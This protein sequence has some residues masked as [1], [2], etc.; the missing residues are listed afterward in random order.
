MTT[1]KP[2]VV[3]TLLG[4]EQLVRLSDYEALQAA[5][6]EEIFCVRQDRDAHFGE[7]MR[8]LEQVDAMKAECEKLRSIISDLKSW[9]CDVSGGFLSIPVDLRSR[10]QEAIVG[11][12][13]GGQS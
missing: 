10:M 11:A 12:M 3:M 1:N 13:Q 5:H 9:D 4:G 7:L 6:E 8:A 2:E